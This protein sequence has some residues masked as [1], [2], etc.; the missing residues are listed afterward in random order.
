MKDASTDSFDSPP[1]RVMDIF[2]DWSA[3]RK[4]AKA[5]IVLLAFRM[6]S[7][8]NNV[9]RPLRYI[10]YPYLIFY[11]VFFEWILG[12][13][14]PWKLSAGPGLRLFHGQA[15]VV[16]DRVIIGRNCIL[17]HATTIGVGKTSD[18]FDGAAPVIGDNVD[19]GS[20]V[21]I[22]GGVHIGNNAVIGAGTVVV[23]D[24]PAGAVVVGNPA[25][26]IRNVA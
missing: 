11:R 3:N 7:L 18:N 13:E 15:L 26:I 8:F 4:N 6:A 20:N 24:V 10:G 9:D 1:R 5:R 17:R 16:N 23:K 2:Q 19:I 12:I 22:V 25:K 21:V 14:L